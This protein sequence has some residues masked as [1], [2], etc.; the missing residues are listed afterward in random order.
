MAQEKIEYFPSS[1]IESLT[2]GIFAFAMTLLVLSLNAPELQG[3]ITNQELIIKLDAMSDRFLIFLLSF[4]LLA[5]AWG[6]HHR[7]FAKITRSDEGLMWI[8]MLRLLFVIMI[9]FSSVLVGNY[10][11]L[12]FAVFFFDMNIFLLSLVSYIE[13]KYALSHD[14]T[15][16]TVLSD[17]E[18]KGNIKNI[19][20]V[21]IAGIACLIALFNTNLSLWTFA[22]IPLVLYTLKRFGKIT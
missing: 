18:K 4:F 14:L 19:V 5:S 13:W 12:T 16:E 15:S 6:V 8:N 3:I 21:A 1:R 11:Q 17:Y 2:D 7:Q 20:P 9:P 22:T 10:S